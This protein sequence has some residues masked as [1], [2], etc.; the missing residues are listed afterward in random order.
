MIA[1]CFRCVGI[2]IIPVLVIWCW[3]AA[4]ATMRMVS[5]DD[6]AQVLAR[7]GL[8]PEVFP[9]IGLLPLLGREGGDAMAAA[10]V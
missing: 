1:D 2:R 6:T 3:L 10:V 9:S 5:K 4:M 7:L 8:V